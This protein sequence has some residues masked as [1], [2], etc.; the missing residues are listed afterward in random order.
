MYS[1]IFP[2]HETALKK[3]ESGEHYF[4]SL[5][6]KEYEKKMVKEKGQNPFSDGRMGLYWA[7]GTGYSFIAWKTTHP[8]FKDPRVREALTYAC[9][10]QRM[11]DDFE[12]GE[13][14]LA[15]GPQHVNT[16]YCP[17]DLEA[18]PFDLA[19]ARNLLRELGWVDTDADGI[20]DNEVEGTRRAFRFKAMVPQNDLFIPIFEMFKEDLKKIGVQMDLEFLEWKQF[21]ERLDARTFE[22]TALLWSGDG[23][24]S[25]MYQIWHS[26]QADEV[27]SSNFIEFRDAECDEMMVRLRETFDLDERIRLQRLLHK[28]IASL[29]PYTFLL[30]YRLPVF[31]WKDR[32]GNFAAGCAYVDRPNVRLYP[33]IRLAPR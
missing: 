9:N 2:T 8:I 20:L 21:K 28:R 30:F 13:A 16:P 3:V 22:C 27:P 15:T 26:S 32:I 10:R 7:W 12:L 29:Y 6:M 24:E 23:W 1:E 33:M 11:R 17:P 18:P 25:D 5:Q 31:W 19:R 4:H 14:A